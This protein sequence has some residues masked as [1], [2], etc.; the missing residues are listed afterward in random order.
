MTARERLVMLVFFGMGIMSAGV[1][2]L[3]LSPA[4][5]LGIGGSIASG[6]IAYATWHTVAKE[7]DL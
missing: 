3:I 7:Y 1:A 6:A 5:I 4:A 2:S